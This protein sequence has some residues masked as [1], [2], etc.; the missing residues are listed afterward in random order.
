MLQLPLQGTKGH[1]ARF[2][3]MTFIPLFLRA[4]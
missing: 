3:D 4:C 2:H 1:L